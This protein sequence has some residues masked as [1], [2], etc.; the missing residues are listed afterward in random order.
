MKKYSELNKRASRR[1]SDLDA[2]DGVRAWLGASVYNSDG[3]D[4]TEPPDPATVAPTDKPSGTRPIDKW[5]L[6]T[7]DIHDPNTWSHL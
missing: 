5:G 1:P 4:K 3:G 7:Q 6:G 2:A